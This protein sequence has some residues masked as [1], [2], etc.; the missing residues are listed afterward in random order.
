MAHKLPPHPALI[1]TLFGLMCATSPLYFTLT[2]AF[3]P[4]GFVISYIVFYCIF[5][6][7]VW[8]LAQASSLN[9]KKPSPGQAVGF[10][11]IPFFALYWIFVARVS[12]A[13]H[14]N[15]LAGHNT[16]PVDLVIAECILLILLGPIGGIIE[17]I[18]NFAFY[19]AAKNI[20]R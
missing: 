11:F 9:A 2:F 12:C 13:K 1:A 7:R 10:L 5:I 3:V 18:N 17:Q 19:R 8:N 16:V 15:H 4:A 20:V 6:Y 14:V